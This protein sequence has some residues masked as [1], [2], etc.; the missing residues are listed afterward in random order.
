M[1]MRRPSPKVRTYR[2]YFIVPVPGGY[3]VW[4]P[5]G[6]RKSRHLTATACRIW[7]AKRRTQWK[8]R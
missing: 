4:S 2:G 3:E 8:G 1:A 7:I 5:T 6:K